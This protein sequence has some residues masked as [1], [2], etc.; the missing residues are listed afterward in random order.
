M[1]ELI[2]F[3]GEIVEW[4]VD[5]VVWAALSIYELF[6]EGVLAVL[7][8]LPVPDWLTGADPFASIDPGVVFF[9]DALRLPEGIAIVVGAYLIRFL[10]RR[11]PGIG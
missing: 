1:S 4:V 5:F 9:V 10:I 11:I 7:E 6:L 2:R 8:L 3:L